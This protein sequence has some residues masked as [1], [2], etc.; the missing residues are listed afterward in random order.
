ME[1][2]KKHGRRW[3]V[4]NVVESLLEAWREVPRSLI[5][6]SFQRTSFRTDD[7]FLEIRCDAWEELK[8][9]TSFERFVTFD[10]DL[11]TSREQ[12]RSSGHNYN[13]R[14]REEV[15]LVDDKLDSGRKLSTERIHDE[16]QAD[17][18]SRR[19]RGKVNIDRKKKKSS[20]KRPHDDAQ[21]DEDRPDE[22]VNVKSSDNSLADPTRQSKSNEE[23]IVASSPAKRPKIISIETVHLAMKG[24]TDSSTQSTDEPE[25]LDATTSRT[26]ADHVL[27]SVDDAIDYQKEA[28]SGNSEAWSGG[29]RRS[30]ESSQEVDG[31]STSDF[32]LQQVLGDIFAADSAM[33]EPNTSAVS[34]VSPRKRTESSDMMPPM[35]GNDGCSSRR[36]PKRRRSRSVDAEQPLDEANDGEPE[37]KKSKS[38]SNWAKRYETT[39][40]FGSTDV[41]RS[42]STAPADVPGGEEMQQ[43][44]PSETQKSIFTIRP[45]K[46]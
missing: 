9:G 29:E 34:G 41:A 37:R 15:V 6:A 25:K 38:D 8:T 18:D 45:K 40:V 23:V 33:R 11:S 12:R 14:A 22:T 43:P 36:S 27:Q 46:D 39:F 1:G 20:L 35:D 26:N 5:I 7:C 30:M 42:V 10:D 21:P 24:R 44:W 2:I 32:A 31:L 19:I 17:G 13:L 16:S 28:I 4:E 3:K